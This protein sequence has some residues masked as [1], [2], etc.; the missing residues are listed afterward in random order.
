MPEA[1]FI[2]Q[3]DDFQG[4]IVKSRYPTTLALTEKVLNLVFYEHQ[5]GKHEELKFSEDIEGMR[6]ASFSMES[7]PGWSVNFVLGLDEVFDNLRTELAGMGRFILELIET[8]PEAVEI[9]KVLAKG[10]ILPPP[11]EEQRTAGI[12]LTP[13]AALLLERLQAE[14]TESTA[15]LSLWLKNQVQ[16]DDVDIREAIA[17][18]M[19][20]GLVIVEIE[21]KTAE[22]A[23]LVKDVFGHRAPPVS[24]FTRAESIYPTLID[25]YRQYIKSFFSPEPPARGY[26]PTIPVDDPNSPL[27]E[28]REKISKVLSNSIQYAVLQTLREQPLSVTEIADRTS[29]PESVVQSALW[30]L[31]ENRIVARFE[32]SGV[33][34][35]VTNP[36]MEV[37]MPE[38]VLFIIAQKMEEKKISQASARRYLQLLIETWSEQSD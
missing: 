26:N 5:K 34:G 23:Y 7:R 9:D 36:V 19:D 27:M 32:V 14:G 13:S 25:Q 11:N 30:T 29:F 17:P 37:F 3:L 4:F 31:E 10:S 33:W 24:S 1:A 18:L 28:D 6:I 16:S 15:K 20:S 8:D 2:V 12:F 38:Y 35:L 22:T 21:G